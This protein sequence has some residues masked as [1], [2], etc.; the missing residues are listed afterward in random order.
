MNWLKN[1][2][3]FFFF[4]FYKIYKIENNIISHYYWFYS[5]F[6]QINAALVSIKDFQKHKKTIE[7]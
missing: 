2:F 5:I 3:L 6:D 7:Q 1:E 4:T